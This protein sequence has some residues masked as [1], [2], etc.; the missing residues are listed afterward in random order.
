VSL[1][2]IVALCSACVWGTGDFC[3]GR[4]STRMDSFQVLCLSALS[5]IVM[6]VALALATG[7]SVHADRGMLW[8]A[9]AGL[10]TAV[11]IAALYRGLSIGNAATVAPMAAVTAAL[12]PVVF[13]AATAGLPVA[14]SLPG[15]ER[16]WLASSWS[17]ARRPRDRDRALGS[18]WGCSPGSA[19]AAFSC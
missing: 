16:R 14:R 2:V 15:L 3:G 11:G 17:H 5:G 7:E 6:L 13:G 18:G 10:C 19:S 8:A 12:L 1:G 9:A 4:A